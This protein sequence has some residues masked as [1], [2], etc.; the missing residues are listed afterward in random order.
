MTDALKLSVVV[1]SYNMARELPRTLQTLAAGFQ[2]DIAAEDYEVIVIDTGSAE[3]VDADLWHSLCPNLRLH[4]MPDAPPSPVPA[5]NFGLGLARGEL[6]GAWID[7]ARMASPRLLATALE[8]ARLHPA[9]IVGTYA[10]HLGEDVQFRSFDRGYCREAEDALLASVDWQADGYRLFT[11]SVFA[12]SS[13]A[14]WFWAPN[15]CNALFMTREHWQRLGGYDPR[16]ETAAGGLANLDAWLRACEG[17]ADPRSII[18]LLG[19]GTFHQIHRDRPEAPDRFERFH[20]EYKRLRGKPFS[21]P[22]FAPVLYGRL[23][24]EALPSVRRSVDSELHRMAMDA[25]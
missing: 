8:A 9:P 11:I 16:F 2:R 14:G 6:V 10:F 23:P 17:A 5:I 12:G 22:A 3:P 25:T 18:M 20:D 4:V 1:V 7:G 13:E 21:R 15:E 24:P 19:E